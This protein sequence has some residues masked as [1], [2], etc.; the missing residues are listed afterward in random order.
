M[1]YFIRHGLK[2]AVKIGT[3]LNVIDRLKTLQ[4]AHP[5]DLYL[6]GAMV[7]D[8]DVEKKLHR[9]F[10]H[11]RIRGEWFRAENELLEY[12]AKNR[13]W[14]A[15]ADYSDIAL[16]ADNDLE[17]R[18]LPV[19]LGI[20]VSHDYDHVVSKDV[21]KI[22]CYPNYSDTDFEEIYRDAKRR[23]AKWLVNFGG[24]WTAYKTAEQPLA[25]DGATAPIASRVLPADV[26]EWEW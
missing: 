15:E 22:C 5:D 14:L 8:E 11:L 4:C 23:G 6:I 12:I 24:Y 25:L 9:Q 17:V 18:I 19:T 2:G 1:V 21:V 20:K 10:S 7:G 26:L 16:E 13:I 3:S